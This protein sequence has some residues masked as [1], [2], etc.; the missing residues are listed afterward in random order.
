MA[1]KAHMLME[2]TGDRQHQNSEPSN[3]SL[4][5]ASTLQKALLCASML[6]ASQHV[7]VIGLYSFVL[8]SARLCFLRICT[9]ASFLIYTGQK[10]F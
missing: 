7:A 6:S 2:I 5:A 9:H 4:S 8:T 1:S 3:D 10:E